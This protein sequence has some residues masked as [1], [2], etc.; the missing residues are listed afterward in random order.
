[1]PEAER[2]NEVR[3]WAE[4]AEEDARAVEILVRAREESPASAI[5]F[6]AQQCVEKYLKAFLT[7]RAVLFPKTHD[8]AELVDLIP[9]AVELRL[10]PEEQ[11]ALTAYAVGTRYASR[12]VGKN[13]AEEAVKVARAAREDLRK[14]LPP[15]A[16]K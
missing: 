2:L 12:T 1:M 13:E 4:K 7:W 10:T 9:E 16:L 3:K 15:A 14:L 11:D 8:L 6:H 5:C